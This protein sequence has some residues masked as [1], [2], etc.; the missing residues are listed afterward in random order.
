MLEQYLILTFI[1]FILIALTFTGVE[2]IRSAIKT[3]RYQKKVAVLRTAHR[4]HLRD[5]NTFFGDNT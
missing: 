3:M 2:V 4:Q 5:K 1:I